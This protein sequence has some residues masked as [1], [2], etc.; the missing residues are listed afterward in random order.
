M[1]SVKDLGYCHICK[2]HNPILDAIKLIEFM[3]ISVDYTLTFEHLNELSLFRAPAGRHKAIAQT[4][5]PQTE[6]HK[7]LGTFRCILAV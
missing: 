4:P 6:F 2:I 7:H 1:P 3:N 5:S